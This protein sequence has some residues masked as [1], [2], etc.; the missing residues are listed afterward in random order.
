MLPH[1]MRCGLAHHTGTRRDAKIIPF[2][3]K[4]K[5]SYQ[6]VR[7][8]SPSDACAGR[9]TKQLSRLCRNKSIAGDNTPTRKA[10]TQG[11]PGVHTPWTPTCKSPRP[12]T[13]QGRP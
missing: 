6:G 2:P 12:W 11:V 7:R 3:K 8:M 10:V 1:D 5:K 13:L 9:G 4:R